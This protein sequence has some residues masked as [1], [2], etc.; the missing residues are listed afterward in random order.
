MPFVLTLGTQHSSQTSRTLG[1]LLSACG[2]LRHTGCDNRPGMDHALNI[3]VNI[4]LKPSSPV[5]SRSGG[6]R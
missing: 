4:G 5:L 6:V 3:V 1:G 2:A